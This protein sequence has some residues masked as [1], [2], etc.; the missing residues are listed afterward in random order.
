MMTMLHQIETINKEIKYKRQPNGN[1][2]IEKYNNRNK[3]I[4][5]EAQL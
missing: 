5:R 2:G 4:T 3:N 1:S